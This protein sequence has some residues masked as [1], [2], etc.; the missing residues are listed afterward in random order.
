[1]TENSI[2]KSEKTP[3][4]RT[5]RWLCFLTLFLVIVTLVLLCYS[6]SLE[7][8]HIWIH[9][10][11]STKSYNTQQHM[12]TNG[13]TS[14]AQP[15]TSEYFVAYPHQY[16][17]ILD[18]P[19][20]CQQESPFLVLVIPVAPH[21]REAR[22][23]IRKTWC[24]E[25]RVLGRVI[26]H[27]FLLG[28][29]KEG[30]GLEMQVLQESQKNHD[31]LQSDFLDTY[32]NLTIKTMV[33]FEWLS[34]HCPNTLYAMKIDSDMFLNVQKLVDM[35]LKAPQH[36]YMTGMLARG[37]LV[38]RDHNSK[39]FLPYS[40]FPESTYPPYALG[41]GYVFSM[42]LPKKIVEA[43]A[44]VKAIY[45]EDVYVGLCMR[46]LNIALTNPPNG[47]LFR[48]IMQKE[49]RCYWTSVI[50]TILGSPKQ[51]LDVWGAYQ[52]QVQGGC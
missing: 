45:I 46:R 52:T 3:W 12:T 34:N 4:T 49:T 18:E 36:L 51:L 22:D 32:N 14:P 16:H 15:S 50:T 20:R 17:F 13:S 44:H 41:L 43:S 6:S 31:I 25:T 27:Y 42:D 38:L 21:N 5:R 19:D 23:V 39:W 40:A 1:M 29:S 11:W 37:A 24:R 47:G 8:L 26:S 9:K 28:R 48:A 2:S 10:I 33:M 30:H 35:L 7:P